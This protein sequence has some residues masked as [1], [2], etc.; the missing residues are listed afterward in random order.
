MKE[1]TEKEIEDAL[2]SMNIPYKRKQPPANQA[3]LAKTFQYEALP[4]IVNLKS[5]DTVDAE[6][7]IIVKNM[8]KTADNGVYIFTVLRTGQA[9][10]IV[11][12]PSTISK[13]P[14]I[15]KVT[16]DMISAITGID[17]PPLKPFDM[18]EIMAYTLANTFLR[19]MMESCQIPEEHRSL[20]LRLYMPRFLANIGLY[21]TGATKEDGSPMIYEEV[22]N[23]EPMMIWQSIQKGA[24]GNESEHADGSSGAFEG[25]AGTD[26][27]G[28]K[29]N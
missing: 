15:R 25:T 18:V 4:I 8:D 22:V 27:Q 16:G 7:G 13:A 20:F 6:R 1:F 10:F 21:F 29:E 28:E 14:M 11:V 9:G 12:I 3:S 2:R 24:Q 19:F 23:M 17:L 5:V 26:A